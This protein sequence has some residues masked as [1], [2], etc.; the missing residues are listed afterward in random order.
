[1]RGPLFDCR[2]AFA[3]TLI[4]L[5]EADGRVVAVCNDSVGSSNLKEF[6][7]RF[8]NRLVNVGIAEQNLVGVGAGLANAGLIPFVC[9]AS[10]FLTA[11]ALEQIKVDV[12]Y[13]RANVKL[14]GMTSGMG[15]GELGATHHSIEDIAW[16]RAIANLTVVV[17][18]DPMETAQ[19]VRA[20]ASYDGPVFL[21]L[22]RTGVPQ[23]HSSDYRFEI[24]RAVQLREGADVTIV[25]NGTMVCRALEAASLLAADG[26]SAAVLNVGTACPLDAGAIAKAAAAGPIVTVEEHTVT[27]GLGSAVA[28]IVVATHPTRMRLLGVPG[29]FAP[30]GSPDFLFEH[31][32]LTPEGIRNTARV[33]VKESA[34]EKQ[35]AHTCH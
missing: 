32:G 2:A 10:C 16:T 35:T 5:A 25:A 23:V 31:F 29:V 3:E 18:A 17:P 14:C 13:S 6:K 8:P 22:S 11:R 30:T 34:S 21:R 33:L 12:G 28:E 26:I 4:S 7:K 15:Y 9:S 19:A 27:G 1:M 20:A 24:G